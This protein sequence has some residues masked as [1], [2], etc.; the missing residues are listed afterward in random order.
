MTVKDPATEVWCAMADVVTMARAIK[1]AAMCLMLVIDLLLHEL[2]RD[3]A[4]FVC[5]FTL[6]P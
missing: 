6:T 3:Q 1:P 5:P 2:Q 4:G